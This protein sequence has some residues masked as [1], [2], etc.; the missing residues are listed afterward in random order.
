MVTKKCTE[1][2][3]RRQEIERKAELYASRDIELKSRRA[4]LKD[5]QMEVR[6]ARERPEPRSN[7]KKR[8][9]KKNSHKSL[10]KNKSC[11]QTRLRWPGPMMTKRRDYFEEER[12]SMGVIGT[13]LDF[14]KVPAT[15][16]C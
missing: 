1:L 8:A 9:L 12:E 14:V 4:K 3:L 15:I 5:E 7:G 2:E 16:T 10:P 13:A 6:K 11:F